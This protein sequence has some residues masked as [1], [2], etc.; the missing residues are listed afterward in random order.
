MSNRYLYRKNSKK[1]E[2]KDVGLPSNMDDLITLLNETFPLINPE[3]SA[4]IAEIQRKAGQRDVVDWLL[5]LKNRK[6]ENVLR[7]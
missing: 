3:P 1:S 5:E 6:D 2:S 7:K 4:S